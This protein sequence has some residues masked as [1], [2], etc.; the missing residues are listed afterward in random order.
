MHRRVVYA[1][2]VKGTECVLERNYKQH[3]HS[4]YLLRKKTPRAGIRRTL[5]LTSLLHFPPGYCGSWV[6]CQG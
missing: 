1:T 6:C 4:Y 2:E 5:A 3:N